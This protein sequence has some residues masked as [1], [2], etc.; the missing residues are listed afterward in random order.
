MSNVI[1]LVRANFDFDAHDSIPVET[2]GFDVV[3]EHGTYFAGFQQM[4]GLY[5]WGW[6][7]SVS[8]ALNHAVERYNG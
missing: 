1:P 4:E 3:K 8:E 2:Q 6:G 5:V 7:Q